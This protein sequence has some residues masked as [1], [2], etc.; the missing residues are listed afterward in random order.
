VGNGSFLP[1][2]TTVAGCHSQVLKLGP[3]DYRADALAA[4]Y[5]L[6]TEQDR[7]DKKE[8]I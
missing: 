3:C 5:C 4:C 7:M 1:K 2:E 8:Q 6:P